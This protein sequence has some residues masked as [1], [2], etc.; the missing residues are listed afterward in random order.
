VSRY[1]TIVA[2]PPWPLADSGPR[3]G[4]TGSWGP[5]EGTKSVIPYQ[6]MTLEE[7]A[8]LPVRGLAARAAHLYLWTVNAYVEDAYEVARLWGFRPSTLITWCKAPM[9]LGMGGTFAST[10]EF[11]LF[12]RRGICPA[13]RRMDTSWFQWKRGAH[14]AKPEAFLDLRGAGEPPPTGRD[15]R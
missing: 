6:R 4:S 11:V 1:R 7:I 13:Q 15:V 9:G 5:W 8:A 2:D 3:T 12:A 10:S 14:S